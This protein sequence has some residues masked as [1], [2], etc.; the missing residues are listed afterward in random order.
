VNNPG[1]LT[2]SYITQYANKKKGSPIFLQD[3]RRLW[4]S[5][6]FDFRGL[7]CSDLFDLKKFRLDKSKN[8]GN[9]IGRENFNS[10]VEVS[11]ITVIEAAG[12]LNAVNT[13]IL[14]ENESPLIFN[15]IQHNMCDRSFYIFMTEKILY[16]IIQVFRIFE[17]AIYE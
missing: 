4:I 10:R 9:D 6:Q 5:C 3:S 16:K 7:S 1:Y 8:G 14:L 13:G 15:D 11:H 17:T 2:I 12:G